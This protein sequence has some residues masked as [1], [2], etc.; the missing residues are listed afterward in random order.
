HARTTLHQSATE[1]RGVM[2]R[3]Q[4]IQAAIRAA[5]RGGRV[6]AI[7]PDATH[8]GAAQWDPKP[9]RA[10]SWGGNSMRP[11]PVRTY[12]H[13]VKQARFE[14]VVSVRSDQ[15]LRGVAASLSVR[16]RRDPYVSHGDP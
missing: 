6:L 9:P 10:W 12:R 16:E 13:A 8:P 3:T 15:H 2:T 7:D 14:H 11:H 5:Y 1:D 4:K